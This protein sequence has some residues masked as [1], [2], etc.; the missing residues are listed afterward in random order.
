MRNDFKL[1]TIAIIAAML[2]TMPASAATVNLGG[3][4]NGGVVNNLLGGGNSNNPAATATVNTGNGSNGGALDL[5]G[6]TNNPSGPTTANVNLGGTN[7]TQGNALLDLFGND[8]NP[9]AA[10]NLGNGGDGVAGIGGVGG[11]DG[12][13]VLDLF[14]NGDG[15]GGNGAGG[16][17]G[18]GGD[19]GNGVDLFGNGGGGVRVASID[20][21]VDTACFAP[22]AQQISKLVNRHVYSPASMSGWAGVTSIKVV[23]VGL[24]DDSKTKLASTLAG[25]ANI[26]RLQDFI[27][28]HSGL[29]SGL[30]RQGHSA[31]DVVAVDRNGNTLV[32]YVI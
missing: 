18:I 12:N 23:Q 3:N 24:C 10:V 25:D 32:V 15:S 14:G 13:V 8:D 2:V 11:P 30:A 9:N 26:T 29:R 22:N 17:G 4:G 20:S 28:A 7:G 6:T 16:N 27:N 31:G 19:G 5:L 21:T 1:S